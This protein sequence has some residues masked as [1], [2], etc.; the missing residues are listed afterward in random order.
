MVTAD[1]STARGAEQVGAVSRGR[2]TRVDAL[3]SN[4]GIILGKPLLET[5]EAEWD[6]VH[7]VDL[8]SVC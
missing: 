3:Y 1:V 2:F 6:R 5:T 4:H 8:K 7:D